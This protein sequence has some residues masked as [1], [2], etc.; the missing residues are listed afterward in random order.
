VCARACVCV[1]ACVRV[2][3]CVPLH[4]FVS[5]YVCKERF[6]DHAKDKWRCE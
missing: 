5:V 2:C 1:C 4:L 6:R 3:E